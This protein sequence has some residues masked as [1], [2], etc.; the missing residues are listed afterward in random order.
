V[1]CKRQ[2]LRLIDFTGMKNPSY[3]YKHE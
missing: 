2:K 1:W 3:F